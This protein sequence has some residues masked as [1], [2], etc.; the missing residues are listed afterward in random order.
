[1]KKI[2]NKIKKYLY[3]RSKEDYELIYEKDCL[4]NEDCYNIKP[5]YIKKIE[6]E[7]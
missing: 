3:S 7:K 1:M 2:I 6:V 4:T 5:L